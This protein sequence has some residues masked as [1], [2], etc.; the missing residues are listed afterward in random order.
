MDYPWFGMPTRQ[1]FLERVRAGGP[2]WLLVVDLDH[3]KR[4]LDRFGQQVGD[5]IIRSVAAIVRDHATGPW[6]AARIGGEE[7]GLWGEG[8]D[9]ATAWALAEAIRLAV[10]AVRV[11]R[12]EAQPWHTAELVEALAAYQPTV[13]VGLAPRLARDAGPDEV[14]RRVDDA[15]NDAKLGG[16]DRCVVRC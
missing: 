9:E 1:A 10:H 16:R 7:F 14:W 5:V 15:L 12:E 3:L 8:V 11:A 2:G 6:E 13:S 4:A